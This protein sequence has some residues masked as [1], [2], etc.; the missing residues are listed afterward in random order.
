MTPAIHR[1]IG[2]LLS[3]PPETEPPLLHRRELNRSCGDFRIF[4]TC[5]R[6]LSPSRYA[7]A[8]RISQGTPFMPSTAD[9]SEMI[10]EPLMSSLHN[11]RRRTSC[12]L[13]PRFG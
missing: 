2:S 6:H 8:P 10:L 12:P 9:Y 1:T 5:K 11:F 4:K 13:S 3:P 7:Q